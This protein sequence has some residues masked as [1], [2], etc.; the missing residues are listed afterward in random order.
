MYDCS[1][2]VESETKTNQKPSIKFIGKKIRFVIIRGR[3][4]EEG[5]SKQG[6]QKVQ[7]SSYKVQSLE[8]NVQ[9]DDCS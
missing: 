1:S 9:H 4:W 7:T 8:Y 5:K 3:D 2:I 6:D